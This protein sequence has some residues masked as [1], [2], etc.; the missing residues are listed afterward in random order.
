MCYR[1]V[2]EG[3]SKKH[4][5]VHRSVVLYRHPD[6]NVPRTINKN[7]SDYFFPTPVAAKVPAAHARLGDKRET[8]SDTDE[9]KEIAV[10]RAA[11][12]VGTRESDPPTNP[13][14]CTEET[15]LDLVDGREALGEYE[16]GLR[17]EYLQLA[18]EEQD[19]IRELS[20]PSN[21][22]Y[23]GIDDIVRFRTRWVDNK[24]EIIFVAVDKYNDP[25]D[26]SFEDLE[27]DAP[28]LLANFI[29]SK[30]IFQ[31]KHA[32]L[33]KWAKGIK[34]TAD[35]AVI[36]LQAHSRRFGIMPHGTHPS[37]EVS[38]R[39]TAPSQTGRMLPSKTKRP[40]KNQ[41]SLEPS[42]EHQFGIRI[43][44]NVEE[45]INFD[46]AN[47]NRLW[48]DAIIDELR[49]LW[50]M[51]TFSLVCRSELNKVINTHQFAPLRMIFNVK[52]CLRRKARLVIGGH[53]V[54]AGGH[55]LY[56]STMKGVS[57]RILMLIAA[58]NGL[59][60]LCGDIKT[61][62]LYAQNL[63]KTYVKL[64]KEFNLLDSSIAPGSMATVEKA[65][66]GLPTSANR[67]HQHL[68]E[69]LRQLGFTPSWYD[70][71][72]WLILRKGKSSPGYDYIG[73]HTDDLMI[74]AKDPQMYMTALQK[75]YEIK[76]IGPPKYHLGC[77][78]EQNEAGNW[79]VGTSTYVVEALDKAKII[80]GVEDHRLFKSPMCDKVK[81]EMDESPLLGV[82]GH[83][84]YQ[85]LIGIL[86]WMITCGRMDI[87]Q[88]VNSL[89]RFS[90]APRTNHL[91]MVARIFGYLRRFPN[92]TLEINVTPHEPAGQV[93]KPYKTKDDQSWKDIYPDAMEEIDPHFPKPL[94]APLTSGIYFDSNH[95]HDEKN[96][97]SVT[98]ILAYVAGT[99]ITWMSKRQGAI[100]TSTYTAEMAAMKTAAEEA[101]SIRYMLRALGVPVQGRTALWGDNL[102]S[103]I[104]TD[105][106][107][108][109]C[110]KKHS[111]VAFHYVRECNAAEIIDVFKVETAHNLADPF[112][113]ALPAPRFIVLFQQIY[114][115][116]LRC[117]GLKQGEED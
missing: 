64:G 100:A 6:E 65:L 55:E 116:I 60:V 84:K 78:Y 26:C 50:D 82:V 102:G 49:S 74:V 53:I 34:A 27:K 76:N 107:G 3:S 46:K 25:Q 31:K 36:I 39:R 28:Y 4:R 88:A 20:R 59:A 33:F 1:V 44:R 45:A 61:A 91:P 68:A 117:I 58:A 109:S 115:N 89:S 57:A 86:Q 52:A 24:Q 7:P 48:Q 32:K 18:T 38:C 101:I 21:E 13:P 92:N 77:D 112:T 51:K 9:D 98:G 99:P 63:L 95:A 73:T 23:Q 5:V 103:L 71:D 15:P 29:L 10:P 41:R 81:P 105:N 75:V 17:Q 79:T 90:A 47:G 106:P 56:A 85:Q 67:W 19:L 62:Y 22:D 2:P 40:S 80:L 66:Y 104:T 30:K 12:A 108:S 70:Q 93:T 54:D 43:P 14:L 72:V 97:R 83:R 11:V 69:T 87:M 42:N 96:R 114:R 8:P 94:G 35:K 110:T 16:I 111:Q 113:K 37:P